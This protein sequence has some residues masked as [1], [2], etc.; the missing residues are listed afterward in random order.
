MHLKY[1]LSWARIIIVFMSLYHLSLCRTPSNG[2]VCDDNDDD[3]DDGDG[4]VILTK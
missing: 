4:G 3:D 1:R 2:I